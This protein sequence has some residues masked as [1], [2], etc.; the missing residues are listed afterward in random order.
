MISLKTF[1]SKYCSIY[2]QKFI[3][4]LHTVVFDSKRLF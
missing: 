2:L 4:G 1:A 3:L